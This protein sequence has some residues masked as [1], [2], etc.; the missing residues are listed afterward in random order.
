M[1]FEVSDSEQKAAIAELDKV[2]A[3]W[4]RRPEVTAVDVGFRFKEGRMTSELAI[5]VH[6]RRK[7]P[8]EALSD[9]MLFPETL[10][11]FPVDVIEVEY[12][13]QASP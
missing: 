1:S 6:V 10:G 11:D 9:Y 7:L 8:K 13:P 12:G 4:L 2:R 5:R 3:D